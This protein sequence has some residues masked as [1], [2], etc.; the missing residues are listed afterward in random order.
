MYTPYELLRLVDNYDVIRT[1]KVITIFIY[2]KIYNLP[3]KL[4]DLIKNRDGDNIIIVLS[5]LY[6]HCRNKIKYENII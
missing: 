1:L 4:I 3:D 2:C 5:I 6:N